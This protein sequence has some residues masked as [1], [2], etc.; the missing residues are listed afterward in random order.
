MSNLRKHIFTLD[1]KVDDMENRERHNSLDIYANEEQQ[2]EDK[3]ALSKQLQRE[4]LRI[5][6]GS[7]LQLWNILTQS[8]R[9]LITNLSW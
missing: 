2:G 1:K 7:R 9:K 8:G 3:A 5:S 4:F 6:S